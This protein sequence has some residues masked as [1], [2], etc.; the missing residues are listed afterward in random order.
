MRKIF[1]YFYK[2]YRKF[3]IAPL[4]SSHLYLK[5]FLFFFLSINLV[6]FISCEILD[7]NVIPETSSKVQPPTITIKLIPLAIVVDPVIEFSIPLC[8]IISSYKVNLVIYE[9]Y[10]IDRERGPPQV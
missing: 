10:R 1:K 8:G 2:L 9:S 6:C 4:D 7:H 5:L 3:D